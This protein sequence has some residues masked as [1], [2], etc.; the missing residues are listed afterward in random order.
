MPPCIT[1]RPGGR[2]GNYWSGLR[3]GELLLDGGCLSISLVKW[4]NEW[5]VVAG[6]KDINFSH[7]VNF[8]V[9][10]HFLQR[11]FFLASVIYWVGVVG[12]QKMNVLLMWV[13][14]AEQ[15][16]NTNTPSKWIAPMLPLSVLHYIC[17]VQNATP[18]YGYVAVLG[19][20]GS[21]G[22][23]LPRYSQ[24]SVTDHWHSAA[25]AAAAAATAAL[26]FF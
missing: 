18:W 21:G 9:S 22:R 20:L 14:V 13:E 4:Q 1:W 16:G 2:K 23:W 11:C 17:T 5:H 19:T 6:I 12:G 24:V 26:L 10:L 25:A 15:K 7:F 8:L 3:L